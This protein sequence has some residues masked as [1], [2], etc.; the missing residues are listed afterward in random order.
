[1]AVVV[2]SHGFRRSR[3][4]RR[5]A[6]IRKGDDA[7]NLAIALRR[8]GLPRPERELHFAQPAREWR[9]DLAWPDRKLA[10]EVEGVS[11]G[12]SRHQSI[13]G[14]Q[15]DCAKYAAAALLGWTVLR[16]SQ[17]Q[18]QDGWVLA[19]IE[20]VFYSKHTGEEALELVQAIPRYVKSKSKPVGGSPRLRVPA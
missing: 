6:P 1:M 13:D 17:T 5:S 19:F 16:F 11:S 18:V 14:Y 12:R 7:A 3:S 8:A 15:E 4:P 10:V 20:H 2:L 9:F